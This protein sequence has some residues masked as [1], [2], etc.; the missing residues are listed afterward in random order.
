MSPDHAIMCSALCHSL[1]D[2]EM[3][4]SYWIMNPI[5]GIEGFENLRQYGI[6][7]ALLNDGK[8]VNLLVTSCFVNAPA[9]IL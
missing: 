9:A 6:S 8:V 5:D 2:V 7:L 4:G 1:C 3:Q